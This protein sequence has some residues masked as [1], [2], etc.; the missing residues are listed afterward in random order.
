MSAS[1]ESKD[2]AGERQPAPSALDSPAQILSWAVIFGY[3]QQVFTRFADER[4]HAVLDQVGPTTSTDAR[5]G[6]SLQTNTLASDGRNGGGHGNGNGSEQPI[7]PVVEQG[8]PPEQD[9]P[10]EPARPG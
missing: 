6:L 9:G 10:D 7:G 8:E 1:T 4:A 3:S 5:I 2:R